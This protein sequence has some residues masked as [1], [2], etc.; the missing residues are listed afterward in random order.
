MMSVLY[1]RFC[2][3]MLVKDELY[4]FI[5]ISSLSLKRMW[6]QQQQQSQ[7]TQHQKKIVVISLLVGVGGVGGAGA[8][9]FCVCAP[10]MNGSTVLLLSKLSYCLMYWNKCIYYCIRR[11]ESHVFRDLNWIMAA[12]CL[13]GASVGEMKCFCKSDEYKTTKIC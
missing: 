2:C 13:F 12:E 3:W 7:P 9:N 4:T 5:C 1:G 10:H 8:G 11:P 6:Q